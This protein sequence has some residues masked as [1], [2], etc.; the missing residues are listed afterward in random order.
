MMKT[1]HNYQIPLLL[2]IQVLQELLE[3]QSESYKQIPPR[4]SWST[5]PDSVFA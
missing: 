4:G 1:H 5:D 3:V 2:L